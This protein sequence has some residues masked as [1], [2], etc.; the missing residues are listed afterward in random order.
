VFWKK[1]KKLTK[2]MFLPSK[3]LVPLLSI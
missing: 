1:G 3:E 2:R